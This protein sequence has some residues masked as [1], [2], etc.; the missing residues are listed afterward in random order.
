VRTTYRVNVG[1]SKMELTAEFSAVS[2][3]ELH[4]KPIILTPVLKLNSRG[5]VLDV[6]SP[7]K[8]NPGE[9]S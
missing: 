9:R 4:F 7:F 3:T 5:T 8:I 6:S 2:W 1:L